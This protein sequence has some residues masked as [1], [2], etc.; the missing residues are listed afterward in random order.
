VAIGNFDGVHR[1]HQALIAAAREAGE[2][3]GRPA[4]ALTFEPHPRSFFRPDAPLFRLTPELVKLVLLERHGLEGAF[5]RRF[6]S[7][8]ASL[9]AEAFVSELLVADLGVAGVVV[10]HDFH[11]G[12]GREGDPALLQELCRVNDLSCT[13]VPTVAE[14][15]RIVSSSVIR[16]ALERGEV[17]LANGFLGYRW[18]VRE[19]VRHGDKRGRTLGYPT[20]NLRLSDNCRL[21]HGIYAVRAILDGR[22]HDA[23]ANFGR[24]PTFDNGAPLLEVHLFDFAGDLYGRMLDVEFVDWIRDEARFDALDGLVAQ[25]DLDCA[26]ARAML[27]ADR[28]SAGR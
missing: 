8:L 27:A 25:M 9:S 19:E 24:R 20:A 14:A 26:Q 2:A 16:T 15:G 4:A 11:F 21:R 5:V 1:G 3:L 12:R 23:V 10:G 22:S 18:F 7:S 13:V 6:D 28:A 17:A